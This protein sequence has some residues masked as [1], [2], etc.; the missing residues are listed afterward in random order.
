MFNILETS[1][2]L[3][4]PYICLTFLKHPIAVPGP[5][6]FNSAI[7][8]LDSITIS[9]LLPSSQEH[10][11]TSYIVYYLYN[12]T[13][14]EVNTTEME[15]KLDGLGP[16]TNVTFTVRPFT[17]CLTFGQEAFIGAT[18]KTIRKHCTYIHPNIQIHNL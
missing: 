12:A 16:S 7:N 15:F 5:V 17:A 10:S 4:H 3:K 8:T 2:S 11:I 6:S 1:Y 13:D 9:W 18:T 14:N